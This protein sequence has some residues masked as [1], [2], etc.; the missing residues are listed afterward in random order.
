MLDPPII[1]TTEM[2]KLILEILH[3]DDEPDKKYDFVDNN[4]QMFNGQLFKNSQLYIENLLV[5][6]FRIIIYSFFFFFFFLFT[7]RMIY[8]NIIV[9][10]KID[11]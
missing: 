6:I 8:I 5:S 1:A 2:E 9:I 7:H 3:A 4:I 11:L 10:Y